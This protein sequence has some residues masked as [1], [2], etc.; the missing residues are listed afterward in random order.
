M[1]NTFLRTQVESLKSSLVNMSVGENEKNK[2][3]K[4]I[5]TWEKR[6]RA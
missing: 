6:L 5:E 2:V 1:E 3:M 4:E